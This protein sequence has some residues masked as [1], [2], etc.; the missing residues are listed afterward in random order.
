MA[1]VSY[2]IGGHYDGKAVKS[3][4]SGLKALTASAKAF[5]FA[6]AGFV[7]KKVFDGVN[8]IVSGST[9]AFISQN[10][11]L[12]K[13][14]KS[15][16]QTNTSLQ[17][18]NQLKNQLSRN[19]F[20][21]DDSL[22][23]ALL[24][25]NQMGLTEEQIKNVMEASTDLASS[26]VMPLD[27]AVK[28]LANTYSGTT[29]SLAKIQPELK[30]LTK[31]QL[32]NGEAVEIISKKYKGFADTM[33]N[34]FS[35]RNTQ[36][37]NAFSDLQA[38]IGGIF[39]GLK[40]VSIGKI[41]EPL[42]KV[43]NWITENR[44]KIIAFILALPE[45]TKTVCKDIWEIIKQTFTGDGLKNLLL[46]LGSVALNQAKFSITS[47]WELIKFLFDDL[48]ALGDLTIGNLVRIINNKIMGVGN[49]IIETINTALQKVLD[50]KAVKWIAENIFKAKSF[51][52]SNVISFRFEEKQLTT[53]NQFT[54]RIADNNTKLINNLKANTSEMI[55]K[56]KQA[57]SS[58]TDD[59]SGL[60]NKLKADVMNIIN[61][62]DI[63][64]ELKQAYGQII[65]DLQE[66][67]EDGVENGLSNSDK[68]EKKDSGVSGILNALGDIGQL[69]QAI[70]TG[71]W[72]G[73]LIYL[74]EKILIKLTEE[75]TA[76][77]VLLNIIT[78][79]ISATIET[80]VP[81]IEDISKVILLIFKPL[82]EVLTAIFSTISV[83][84]NSLIFIIQ[85][86]TNMIGAL[87]PAVIDI[88]NIALVAIE[89]VGMILEV[90]EPI[91]VGLE[92]VIK[93]V[94]TIISVVANTIGN[95]LVAIHNAVVWI[96]N[97]IMDL[98]N[99]G[100]GKK[101]YKDFYN[102]TDSITKIWNGLDKDSVEKLI[103]GAKDS[104]S[105]S[106]SSSTG[107]SYTAARDIYVNIY[108]N[109]SY[110]NGDAREIALNL[111]NEIRSAEK[112][113]L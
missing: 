36:F 92:Y 78:E 60:N 91:L 49:T 109:N 111:R 31:E 35:G 95:V 94:S 3:A 81:A 6:V 108:Y 61:N 39:E 98:F 77:A 53:F 11:A 76:F 12:I 84:L 38:S 72:I 100:R 101:S 22:N 42:N 46:F 99:K 7:I 25:C 30:N 96:Y 62:L 97:G 69:I 5:N 70:I 74:V 24:I 113:G 54:S 43:T 26:G 67:I 51:D 64:E 104:Y 89:L 2:K 20:F 23:N 88:I 8:K 71:G 75:C 50:S 52:G 58:F 55:Q 9:S 106:S 48:L 16:T 83:T 10:T 41:L 82:S 87:L 47:I 63:P 103:E 90:L 86:I 13:Y 44:N 112:L 65:P 19:N 93:A 37:K 21:D 45:I 57:F 14:Q 34:T 80:L 28:S 27:Q 4:Q 110:I 107:A 105:N 15:L 66:A 73:A 79:L 1:S 32:A 17:E 18:M 102:Y 85:S 68:S 29:G 40:F 33:S 56:Q 59:Y